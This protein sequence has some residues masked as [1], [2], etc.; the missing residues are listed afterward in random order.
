MTN[1]LEP[2]LDLATLP[3]AKINPEA[4]KTAQA[5]LLDWIVCGRAGQ[6]EPV[7]SRLRQFATSEGGHSQAT[8]FGGGR[9][10]ARMA[11]LVNGTTSHALDYDD[12]HFAHVGHLSVGIYPAALAVGEVTKASAENVIDAFVIGSEVAIRIGMMLGTE[13]YQRGFHQTATAGAF[14]AT[15]AAGRLIGLRRNQ[16]RHALNLVATRAAGLKSQFGTMGKPLNAGFSASNGVEAAQLAAIGVSSAQDAVFGSQ[17]FV[18][19]HTDAP[20]LDVFAPLETW[21]LP[22]ISYKFHACCHGTHA[23]IEAL[24]GLHLND[25]PKTV[26]IRTNPRWMSVCNILSPT[27]GLE[28]KF[29][30]RWLAAMVLSDRDTGAAASYDDAVTRDPEIS[31]L[32]DRIT[33]ESDPSVDDTKVAGEVVLADGTVLP[34]AHDLTAPIASDVLIEKLFTKARGLLGDDRTHDLKPLIGDISAL[35]ASDLAA[36]VGRTP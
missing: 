13:H 22:K 34:L 25:M 1:L 11:A 5:S 24:L 3:S 23:M 10:P 15:V 7:A 28:V 32:A 36:M 26:N 20:Q 9:V 19:T 17:G 18:P 2:F 35:Q 30:Y 29:S 8:M 4:R 33:I 12:T 21:L 14:G 31:A 27:T 16:I 6:S